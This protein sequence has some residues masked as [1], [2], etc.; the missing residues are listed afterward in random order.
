MVILN[1]LVVVVVVIENANAV[2]VFVVFLYLPV[3][4]ARLFLYS[5]TGIVQANLIGPLL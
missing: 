2:F 5:Q 4:L 1:K 3:K